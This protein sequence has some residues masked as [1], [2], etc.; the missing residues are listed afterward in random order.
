MSTIDD[1]IVTCYNR[2]GA[3]DKKFYVRYGGNQAW[4]NLWKM[5]IWVSVMM[6]KEHECSEIYCICEYS[7]GTLLNK[8]NFLS[9]FYAYY[10]IKWYDLSNEI[11]ERNK[12]HT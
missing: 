3:H 12:E 8:C 4:N 6:H 5:M 7:L 2:L 11:F 1:C 9:A 10:V